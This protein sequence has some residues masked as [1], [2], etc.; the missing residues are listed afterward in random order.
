VPARHGSRHRPA[1]SQRP[2]RRRDARVSPQGSCNPVRSAS[3]RPSCGSLPVRPTPDEPPPV[4]PQRALRLAT[5]APRPSP[6][7]RGRVGADPG[8]DLRH[9]WPDGAHGAGTNAVPSTYYFRPISPRTCAAIM[10]I[11][12]LQGNTSISSDLVSQIR[13]PGSDAQGACPDCGE[14]RSRTSSCDNEVSG[15]VRPTK[16][17]GHRSDRHHRTVSSAPGS[18]GSPDG[19]EGR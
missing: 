18:D 1:L 13:Q 8:D 3:A 11:G 9:R 2:T 6:G 14:M 5:R 10:C 17:G 12:P 7:E 16:Y 19:K 15:Q 4:P